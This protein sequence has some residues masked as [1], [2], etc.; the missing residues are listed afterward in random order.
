LAAKL[1]CVGVALPED[2]GPSFNFNNL[3]TIPKMEIFKKASIV[4][5]APLH[6]DTWEY[7]TNMFDIDQ[8]NSIDFTPANFKLIDPTMLPVRDRQAG[9]GPEAWRSAGGVVPV[10]HDTP[11][12]DET[13]RAAIQLSGKLIHDINNALVPAIAEGKMLWHVIPIELIPESIRA[14]FIATINDMNRVPGIR[15]KIKIVTTRQDVA[16]EIAS[17]L[18]D[19]ANTVDAAVANAEAL[20][21]LPQGVKALVFEGETGDFRQMEG[22]IAA[23]RAL[24]KNDAASLI[25]LYEIMT[26]VKFTGLT[27]DL[28][29]NFTN[30]Q[31][32]AKLIKFTL[33]PIT[34]IPAD[35]LKRLNDAMLSMLRS[36]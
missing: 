16:G 22:I 28:Y 2:I 21:N 9:P 23:L 20:K 18:K 11:Q 35:E 12:A 6:A 26:G 7:F 19:P 8:S 15:E 30:P 32:L 4:A 31:D 27:Q 36:A 17:L 3:R 24:H 25:K 34:Q 10:R 33:K 1:G 5:L 14:R 29:A 13:D